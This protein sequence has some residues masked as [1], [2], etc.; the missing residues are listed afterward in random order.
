MPQPFAPSRARGW[1]LPLLLACAWAT[2]IAGSRQPGA[3]WRSILGDPGM[4]DPLPATAFT[5]WNF[6]NGAR[7]PPAFS[8]TPAPRMA[9]CV[10][11]SGN[12]VSAAA[13]SLGVGTAIPGFPD[14]QDV[15][16]YARDK[17]LFL[18][19]LCSRPARDSALGN[20]TAGFSVMFKS[21]N[22]DTKQ[23]LCP[24]VVEKCGPKHAGSGY[25]NQPLVVHQPTGA[26]GVGFFAG[27]YDV[28]PNWTAT[29]TEAVRVALRNHTE[30]WIAYRAAER[31]HSKGHGPLPGAR[32]VAPPLLAHSS[33]LFTA[34]SRDSASLA[35]VYYS[36]MRTS[37]RYPWL[38]NYLR[39]NDVHGGY[40]GYP[41]EGS[42]GMFG[43][44]PASTQMTATLRVID[45][46]A[47][48][49]Q[50]YLPELSGCW[51]LDGSPCDGD[52]L[53]DV[54][55]YIC[56]VMAPTVEPRCTADAQAACP[57]YHVL[58]ASG[59]RVYRN[60][61]ERFP[62][63]CYYMHCYAPND[64]DAHG[65]ACDPYSNPNPQELMQ[66]LPCA[67]WAVHGF[68]GAPGEGWVNDTRAWTLDVGALGAQV[69]LG[70]SEPAAADGKADLRPRATELPAGYPGRNR[71]WI[72]FE[73][74]PE[75]MDPEGGH[76]VRWEVQ[77]WD[78]QVPG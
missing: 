76:M 67:E 64:P 38:M 53:T 17:E 22:M 23:G 8:P 20:Y 45:P 13:N 15:D 7:A 39:A 51:K 25:M 70:G 6:C 35:T 36:A 77:G 16:V 18:G 58:A 32:P 61:T 48:H 74:G 47:P 73:I 26:G 28:L 56:F 5:A 54:T 19:R 62:Y 29:N 30:A 44:A 4:A 57:P 78:V 12:A 34:W 14:T 24:C 52:I 2:A 3:A 33:F 55:R 71:S 65:N 69:F 37:R 40:G 10:T 63:S 41:W 31:Q 46:G 60:D 68:P 59:E 75:Q 1:Q 49:D 42:G 66:I 50:F 11:R 72:S 21:G 43:P 9:D 27:T